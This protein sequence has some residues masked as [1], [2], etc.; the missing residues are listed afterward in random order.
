MKVGENPLYTMLARYLE[1]AAEVV[2]GTSPFISHTIH[3]RLQNW[4]F[5]LKFNKAQRNEHPS[6]G[7]MSGNPTQ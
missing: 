5:C 4:V 7:L 3:P 2:L 1:L 6:P